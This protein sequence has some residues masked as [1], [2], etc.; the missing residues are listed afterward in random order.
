M[1]APRCA[2]ADRSCLRA[3]RYAEVQAALPRTEIT[4]KFGDK[5]A[6]GTAFETNVFQAAK[7]ANVDKKLINNSLCAIVRDTNGEPL[8]LVEGQWDMERPLEQDCSVELCDFE[9]KASAP[10]LSAPACLTFSSGTR[11]PLAMTDGSF[12]P[13]AVRV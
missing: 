5:E 11:H 8:G 2:L 4:I 12:T 7:A 6:K 3:D 9:T 1:C 13:T 10:A